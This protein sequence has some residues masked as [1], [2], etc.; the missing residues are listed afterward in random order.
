MQDVQ[1][2]QFITFKI[3]YVPKGIVDIL[4]TPL[5]K[6]LCILLL[7]V[8]VVTRVRSKIKWLIK[9]FTKINHKCNADG[10]SVTRNAVQCSILYVVSQPSCKLWYASMDLLITAHHLNPLQGPGIRQWTKN[11]T[12]DFVG[13]LKCIQFLL[14]HKVTSNFIKP[15][16]WYQEKCN[17]YLCIH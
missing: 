2:H 7:I 14:L 12:D 17:R 10:S 15:F 5:M 13:H 3:R 4:N 16:G 1:P 8:G 6:T 9:K 11:M